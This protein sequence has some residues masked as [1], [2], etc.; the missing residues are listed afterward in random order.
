MSELTYLFVARRLLLSHDYLRQ[1]TVIRQERSR[2][3]YGHVVFRGTE[4]V[5][6]R[7]ICNDLYLTY[8]CTPTLRYSNNTTI[9]RSPFSQTY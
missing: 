1:L 3:I 9:A 8:F 4:Y 6:I 5:K 7:R 2:G